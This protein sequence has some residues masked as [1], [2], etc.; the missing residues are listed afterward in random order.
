MDSVDPR[1]I[2][3]VINARH[4][5]PVRVHHEARARFAA[6]PLA[7]F[8]YL[9]GNEEFLRSSRADI[10][11]A[12]R[13][14]RMTL[15]FLDGGTGVSYLRDGW[16]PAER[17]GVWS[18][19]PVASLLLPLSD[20]SRSPEAAADGDLAL[21]ISMS[22]FLKPPKLNHQWVTI[23][24]NGKTLKRHQIVF[25][26]AARYEMSIPSSALDPLENILSFH[27]AAPTS[28]AEVGMG[29]DDRDLGIKLFRIMV[30]RIHSPSIQS[31]ANQ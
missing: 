31:S 18:N 11:D 21:V 8:V 14:L 17:A 29:D 24:L 5:D 19:G 28:P 1:A 9:N 2:P 20:L 23:R 15:A 25:P 7:E 16:Y 13:R 27:I 30:Q 4:L 22:A 3:F 10:D 26:G 6:D 12:T